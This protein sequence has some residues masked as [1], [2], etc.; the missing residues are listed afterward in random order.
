MVAAPS[1]CYTDTA[2][3]TILARQVQNKHETQHLLTKVGRQVFVAWLHFPG[4]FHARNRVATGRF[5]VLTSMMARVSCIT[6]DLFT[7]SRTDEKLD[8]AET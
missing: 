6:A 5:R 1:C 4:G 8:V 7:H 3:V 2:A